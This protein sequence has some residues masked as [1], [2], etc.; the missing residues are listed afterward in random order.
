MGAWVGL[1]APVQLPRC[2]CSSHQHSQTCGMTVSILHSSRIFQKLGGD[3]KTIPGS[4]GRFEPNSV[5]ES[6]M[7]KGVQNI[8]PAQC[9]LDSPPSPT[10]NILLCSGGQPSGS[11]WVGHPLCHPSCHDGRLHHREGVTVSTCGTP[12]PQ[13]L[14]HLKSQGP[15]DTGGTAACS[16]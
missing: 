15:G 8:F 16:S 3:L 7:G 6:E 2:C 4:D 10:G 14:W 1:E 5:R 9:E 13:C 12:K 11:T